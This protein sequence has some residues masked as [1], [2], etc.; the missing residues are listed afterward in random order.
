VYR[1]SAVLLFA[2]SFVAW[3]AAEPAKTPAKSATP[4]PAVSKQ[5]AAPKA[6]AKRSA[7]APEELHAAPGFK[8][9]LL[10]TAEPATE[11]SWIAMCTEPGGRLIISG[12]RNQPILRVVLKDGKVERIE[13]LDLPITE[14]MGLLHAFNSLYV[15]GNGPQGFGLYRCRDI[16][17][18][19]H[20]DDVKFLKQFQGAGEHGP[21]GLAAGPDG[22]IYVMNGN[23]TRLPE[24]LSPASPHRNFQ[25]DHLLPRQWDGNGHAAGILAPG[26][27]VV[28]TDP[29]GKDWE[30]VLAGFR[31]AYDLAFNGDGELFT[32]DSDMEWDWGM[33]W[34]RPIRVNHCVT[35]AEFGWRSGTGKWPAYYPDSLPATLDVGLGSPT[36]VTFGTSARFPAKYQKA[37]YLCD[38]TYGRLLAVHLSPRGATY[39]ATMENFVA[40]LGLVKDSAP[41]KPL[42]LTDVV[43]GDDGALY[44]TTGGRNTQGALYRVTYTGRES[45]APANLHETAGAPER[46]LRHDLEAFHGKKDAKALA[47]AWPHL[48]DSDRF[49]RYAAR[50]AVESQDV[51]LWKDRALA[52][53]DPRAALAAL[54]ALA[55][56]GVPA[57]RN[58][59]FAALERFPLDSLSPDL[60]LEKLRV[61]GVA[62]VRQGRPSAEATRKVLADLHPKFPSPDGTLNRELAQVLIYLQAPRIVDRCFARMAAAKSQEDVF[63][64]LFHLRTLPIGHWTL[65]QRKEYFTYWTADRQKY[66]RSPE[67][68]RWFAAAG[69]PYADGSSFKNFLKNFLR[70]ATANLSGA[71]RQAL[72]KQLEAIDRAAIVSYDVKPR[73]VVKQWRMTDLVPDLTAAGHGRDFAR[74][75]EAYLAGQCI[76][77]HRFGNDGGAVGPDLTAIAARFNRR[78]LLESILEPSKVIS[79]QYQNEVFTTGKGKVLTGRVVDESADRLVI[80]PDPLKPER[81]EV[82]KADLDSRT[83]SKV[84]PMPAGLVDVLSRDEV[85]DLIAYLESTGNKGHAAFKK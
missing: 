36:G 38:W 71:E 42:N 7:T 80:Q 59:L 40:P 28:R 30:L 78:E 4:K 81:V 54:L 22:K 33:P 29:E 68:A 37:L 41:K 65:P 27:Y 69:R 56:C 55:R 10:H 25:E 6:P 5:P 8:V 72:A 3:G 63:H 73:P 60:K 35:G 32:F 11:G 74:G 14:A 50:I 16:K 57:Q 75:K 13:K 77:C 79:D 39:A 85:L 18:T 1:C 76:K 53:K 61:L 12:Q 23:H 51:A 49:V 82:L 19:G 17:G 44:F 84:S 31:N 9:E 58:E 43:I 26:G 48:G 15:N 21:H 64:Y 70:E 62:F 52:E 83:P 34:Y 24:G 47:L 66:V 2:F 45:T 20:Y 67:M 46:K